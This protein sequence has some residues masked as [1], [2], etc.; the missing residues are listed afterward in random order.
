MC[1]V[2]N[3]FSLSFPQD[4]CPLTDSVSCLGTS[5]YYISL[6]PHWPYLPRAS[7]PPPV[8]PTHYPD[9]FLRLTLPSLT[10]LV[11]GEARNVIESESV[12]TRSQDPWCTRVREGVDVFTPVSTHR[13]N[14][15][16]LILVRGSGKADVWSGGGDGGTRLNVG[17]SNT[18]VPTI[19]LYLLVS[20]LTPSCQTRPL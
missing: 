15:D 20:D 16:V 17:P 6:G 10:L 4:P 14:C 8:Y 5:S 12:L 3:I 2:C 18:F 11:S 19:P 9:L 7:S 1:I 13:H